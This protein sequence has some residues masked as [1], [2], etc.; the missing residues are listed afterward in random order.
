MLKLIKGAKGSPKGST[1]IVNVTSASPMVSSMR[2]SNINF[3][4]KSEDLPGAE[5]PACEWFKAWSYGNVDDMAYVW[6]DGYN[7]S[8]VANV[9]FGISANQRLF[10][11]Y[12]V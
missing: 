3:E 1:R 5:Q 2:W 9:L 8:K 7:R 4:K 11:K 10:Y 12:G 6:Q